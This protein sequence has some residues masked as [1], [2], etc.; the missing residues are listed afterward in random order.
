MR[1]PLRTESGSRR[2]ECSAARADARNE[3]D[4]PMTAQQPRMT[5]EQE[6]RQVAEE[7]RETEWAGR[8][9]LRE[10]F[11]G[12]FNPDLVFPFPKTNQERPEFTKFYGELREFL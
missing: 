7:S 6:S 5:S 3:G 1:I 2:P 9:F 4:T 10:L 8:G 12:Q 11:L